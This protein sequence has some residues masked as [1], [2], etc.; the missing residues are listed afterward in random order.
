MQWHYHSTVPGT[1][2]WVIFSTAVVKDLHRGQALP[3]PS[4]IMTNGGVLQDCQEEEM[5]L[6]KVTVQTH[7]PHVAWTVIVTSQH[8]T[9]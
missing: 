9:V 3:A 7:G 5:A 1:R 6:S 8:A 4:S 2:T